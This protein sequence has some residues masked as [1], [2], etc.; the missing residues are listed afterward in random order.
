MYSYEFKDYHEVNIQQD[1]DFVETP[2]NIITSQLI[3]S[4]IKDRTSF[5]ISFQ[6]HPS[7]LN[8]LSSRRKMSHYHRKPRGKKSP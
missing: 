7:P 3:R 8:P 1:K 2:L 5:P 6:A 4:S